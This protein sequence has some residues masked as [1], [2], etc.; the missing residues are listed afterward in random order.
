MCN[1]PKGKLQI[2]LWE[3]KSYISA[4]CNSCRLSCSC[5]LYILCIDYFPYHLHHQDRSSTEHRWFCTLYSCLIDIF[6]QLTQG[7]YF[8]W[9]QL[10]CL[11]FRVSFT[12]GELLSWK[13]MKLHATWHWTGPE[14]QDLCQVGRDEAH[15]LYVYCSLSNKRRQWNK[16]L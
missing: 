16:L 6:K 1:T 8:T 14:P 7:Y 5:Y 4:K 11:V 9:R 10:I 3:L 12:R 2:I 15:N 13:G